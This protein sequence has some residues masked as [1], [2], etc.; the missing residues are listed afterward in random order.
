[1]VNTWQG[2]L[3]SQSWAGVTREVNST[4]R[5]CE[6]TS[7]ALVLP[8]YTSFEQLARLGSKLLYKQ[9]LEAPLRGP[10]I[11]IFIKVEVP[12]TIGI[13]KEAQQRCVRDFWMNSNGQFTE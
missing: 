4:A 5:A 7:S 6:V 10:E 11:R 13:T 12:E 2:R 9:I 3:G 8:V 1:M